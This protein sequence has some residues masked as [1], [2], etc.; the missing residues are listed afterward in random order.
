MRD[1]VKHALIKTMHVSGMLKAARN[2][3]AESKATVVLTFH[4]VIPDNFM[5][6]CRSPR[7]MVIRESSFS[8]LLA[9]L[10]E[11]A[12][13]V[14]PYDIAK[15][16]D[17]QGRPRVL[18]TFDDG[19]ADNVKVAAPLL[20][21][22]D[23]SA[24]F[25]AVTGYAGTSQPFWPERFLGLFRSLHRMDREI[26]LK[27]F[28]AFLLKGKQPA[29]RIKEMKEEQ[30]LSWLKGFPPDTIQRALTAAEQQLSGI[31]IDPPDPWERLMTW[32]ELRSLAQLGH[33][34]ASHTATHA[35]LTQL[36]AADASSELT[37]SSA[38]LQHCMGPERAETQWI[39]YPNGYNDEMVRSLA[40]QSGYRYGFTTMPGLWRVGS[41]ALAIPRVNVWDGTVL[42]PEGDF[43]ER[44]LEYN[45]F[46][47]PL[48]AGTL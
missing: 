26:R 46:W 13:I 35:L 39:A 25:F 23:M 11:H 4:R 31:G 5:G 38:Q 3:I 12:N 48:R 10:K 20:G 24:C 14:R 33:S 29:P 43:D 42:S 44:C 27:G 45:L 47:R 15:E 7:G 16:Q 32:S 30:L 37:E 22:C 21:D 19:W 9:Y 8:Q 36:K 34:I 2:K 40:Y 6:S 41:E 17:V 18:L 1:E 28:F